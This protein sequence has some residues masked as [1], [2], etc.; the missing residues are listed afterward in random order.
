MVKV[1]IEYC[2]SWGYEPRMK[3]LRSAILSA[4]PSADVEGWL[5]ANWVSYFNVSN[6]GRVGRRSSFEVTVNGTVIHTKLATMNFPD[7]AETVEIVKGVDQGKEPATV[8]KMAEG[9]GCN[10]L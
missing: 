6:L 1:D 10:I 9:G 3:E 4:V 7:V 8:S 2:G 5:P